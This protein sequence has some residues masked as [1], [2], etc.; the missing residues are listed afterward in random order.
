MP[1]QLERLRG[2]FEELN[3]QLSFQPLE[4]S[5][6]QGFVDHI[7]KIVCYTD[8]QIF[9]RFHRYRAKEKFTKSKALTLRELQTLQPGDFVTHIDY[10]IAKFAGLET[11]FVFPLSFMIFSKDPSAFSKL[12]SSKSP[13]SWKS[14]N[15]S[16]VSLEIKSR[17]D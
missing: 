15:H 7:L 12:F 2:V 16:R 5:L 10:G 3:P 17:K 9:E 6:R 13:V 11:T 8:H 1:R 14:L 4:F